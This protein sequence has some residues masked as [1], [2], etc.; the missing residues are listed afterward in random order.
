MTREEI[1]TKLVH[2]MAEELHMEDVRA[3]DIDVNAPLFAADGVGLDS[4][5]AVELVVVVEKHFGL[6]I[7]DADEAKAAFT[8]VRGLAEYI[9]ARTA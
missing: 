5:D 7:A 1:E 3:E 8:T 2:A 4:L 9:L 6:S